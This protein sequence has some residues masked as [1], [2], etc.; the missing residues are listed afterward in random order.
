[1]KALRNLSSLLLAVVLGSGILYAQPPVR[2]DI[3]ER[4]RASRMLAAGLDRTYDTTAKA[5]TPAPKGYKATYIAHYGRH[6]SRYAYT[7]KTYTIP[8]SMLREGSAAGNLTEYG[9]KLL[10][11]MEAFWKEGE[12]KVGDLTPAGWNQHAWIARTMVAS[13]PDAFKA[14]SRVDASSSLSVRSIMSMSSFCASIA[15]EAPKASVYAHTGTLDIQATRPNMGKN[16]F[17]YTG[18]KLEFPYPENSEA[19]FLRKFPQYPEVLG[20]LFKDPSVCL[21][22]RSAYDVF[23]YLYM[24][25]AG[26]NSIPPEERLDLDPLLTDEEFAILWETDNYERFREYYPYCTTCSSIVDDMVAKADARLASGSAGADLRFGHDHVLMSLLMIM[27][28]NGAGVIPASAEDL[29]YHFSTT[30]SPMAT[31]LQLVFYTPKCRKRGGEP[32][33]KLLLNGEE[34]RFGDLPTVQGPYYNWVDVRAYLRARTDL[35]VNR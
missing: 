14:G 7:A 19:F 34:A 18:P 4:V 24:L 30:D 9:Q 22:G 29:V 5:L 10:G 3:R 17:A 23:F 25:V 21:G 27:D 8:L 1:M 32:L 12:H 33:V 28:I 11:Q 35:F 2:T 15:R 16:P 13:F 6:G 20:R 26:M 31:N